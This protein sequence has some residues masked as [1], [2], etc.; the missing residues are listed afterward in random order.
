MSKEKTLKRVFAKN[1]R[2]VSANVEKYSMVIAT[3]LTSFRR[4]TTHT[5]ER[6]GQEL[7]RES[8]AYLCI[9]KRFCPDL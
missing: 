3:N 9:I 6:S 4:K 1:E 2:G 8:T 5:Q 7:Y